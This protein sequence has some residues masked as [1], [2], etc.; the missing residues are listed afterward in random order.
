[1]ALRETLR[2]TNQVPTGQAGRERCASGGLVAAAFR[3]A[4]RSTRGAVDQFRDQAQ[5][6]PP[7][8]VPQRIEDGHD[9]QR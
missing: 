7:Y 9:D 4:T 3:P 2:R 5:L 1:M 8:M 6:I